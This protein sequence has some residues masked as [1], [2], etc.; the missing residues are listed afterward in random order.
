MHLRIIGGSSHKQ[1][2][3]KVCAHL[4]MSETKTTVTTF[5]NDNLFVRI[6]EPV[7]GDDVFVIQTQAPPV[8]KHLMELLILIRTLR[9]ASAGRITVVVPY[10]PYVR[11]DKKDQ[12]RVCITAKLVADLI[13]TAGAHRVLVMELHNPQIQ[14][15]FSIP[16]DH[17]IGAPP[18]IHHLKTSWN[19][20]N[21]CLVAGD[22]GATKMVKLYADGL[23]LPVAI[24]DKRR[25]GNNETVVIKGV[26]GD[27]HGKKILLIDDETQTGS[28]L[29]HD[30][31]YLLT[32][33]GAIS[34]DACVIH[35]ALGPQAA[36]KLN[37][38]PL[39]T[40]VTTDTI[41]TGEYHLKNHQIISVTHLFA[42][43]IR[44]I[45]EQKSIRSLNEIQVN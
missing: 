37:A 11:S 12:P 4:G 43:C 15:F 31:E 16:C 30:A 21:Y 2:T 3:Q 34:V 33:A 20:T 28:T 35:P 45:H 38:S 40:F 23:D 5:S 17:L 13:Q 41:P 39:G 26:I 19:L 25:E 24:M 36:K 14:G 9:D 8:D 27:V 18:I 1:F 44:R 6:N 7:R 10:L 29:I 42:E 32:F 22:A